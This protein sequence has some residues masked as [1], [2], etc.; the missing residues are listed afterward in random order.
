MLLGVQYYR[1]PSPDP[2]LWEQDIADIAR[3]GFGTVQLWLIWGW[4]ETTQGEFEW[5]DYDRLLDLAHA[6]GLRVV[7][8][9]IAEMQPAWLLRRYPDAAMVDHLGRVTPSTTRVEAQVGVT[10]GGSIDDPRV[11]GHMRD[12][13]DAAAR[14]FA[15]HP[16]LVAWDCWNENRWAMEGDGYL[17]YS[18]ASIRAFHAWLASRYGNLDGVARAWR[19]RFAT[20]DDVQPGRKPGLPYTDLVAFQ[21][22]L[23]ERAASHLR[24]RRDVIRAADPVHPISA[25]CGEP[26]VNSAGSLFEQPLSRGND[27]ALAAELDGYGCSSFP[28]LEG[29]SLLDLGLRIEATRSAAGDRPFWLAE[30]QG[31]GGRLGHHVLPAVRADEQQRWLWNGMGRGAK[32]TIV[33]QWRDEVLGRESGGFGFAGDDG[34]ASARV[35]AMART[36]GILAE[37]GDFLDAYRPEPAQVGVLFLPDTYYLEWA[38]DGNDGRQARESVLGWMRAFEELQLPY[39]VLDP[40]HLSR[41]SD[42][43]LLVLPWPLSVPEH[44]MAVVTAWVERGGLLLTEAD[45]TAFDSEAFYH[46]PG[47]RGASALG[48]RSLGRRELPASGTLSLELDGARF[49]L[50]AASWLEH[51]D[52]TDARVLG[53]DDGHPIAVERTLDAGSVISIGSFPGLAHSLTPSSELLDFASHLASRAGVTTSA[54]VRGTDGTT[55]QWRRG[56]SGDWSVLFLIGAPH[57]EHFVDIPNLGEVTEIEELTDGRA[58]V[59]RQRLVLGLSAWGVAMVR[60]R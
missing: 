44:A 17:D 12:F 58:I 13:L 10:P 34:H 18:P 29:M 32:G 54:R 53:T 1:P 37:H 28:N 39:E 5:G 24:F 48:L 20:W 47:S 22:F 56:T 4:V 51:Y 55:V 16:A 21:R 14:H 7:I 30:L 27:F 11:L 35:E 33:W 26:S 52:P 25:H 2:S 59:A 8:S 41:L 49:E 19:R 46:P 36:A 23:T 6:R 42:L 38:Q 40:D 43:K 9:T 57:S 50:P 31:G 3:A 60:W 45:L 15:S